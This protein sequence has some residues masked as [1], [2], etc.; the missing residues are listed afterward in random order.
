MTKE[1]ITTKNAPAALASYNQAIKV[2][3]LIFTAGQI[4][5]DPVSGK[6]LDDDASAQAKQA[7][8]N[9][10]AILETAGSSLEKVVKVTIF[11]S[12]LNDYAAVNKIYSQYF[13]KDFPARSAVEVA[14]LPKNALIEIEVIATL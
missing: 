5:I 11:L 6:F 7:L 3:E 1:I 12:D 10:K 9:I 13:T 2:G 8:E 14:R 4:G